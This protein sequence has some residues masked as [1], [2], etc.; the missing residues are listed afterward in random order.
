MKAIKITFLIFSLFL[1]GC[2]NPKEK[3]PKVE[4]D[5]SK[6]DSSIVD[7]DNLF[8]KKEEENLDKYIQNIYKKTKKHIVV[9][10]LKR[11][12]IQKK[13]WNVIFLAG[14]GMNLIFINKNW[15]EITISFGEELKEKS[16]L[17]SDKK[18][19]DNQINKL[20][21]ENYYSVVNAIL[22]RL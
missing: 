20:N 13:N 16:K 9:T 8:S 17:E 5:F 14:E 15:K 1:F 7:T 4:F 22:K 3:P 6:P 18:F 2:K 21:E 12:N 19:I 10:T 11:E